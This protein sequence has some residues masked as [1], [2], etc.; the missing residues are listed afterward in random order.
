[1]RDFRLRCRCVTPRT[2]V[3]WLFPWSGSALPSW[4]PCP[5]LVRLHAAV[6]VCCRN[7][8][9]ASAHIHDQYLALRSVYLAVL[10][11]TVI[12]DQL[13]F[14]YF[15]F[16]SVLDSLY[17]PYS[18]RLYSVSFPQI[19]Y[20]IYKCRLYS[21]Q[22]RHLCTTV[23]SHTFAITRFLCCSVRLFAASR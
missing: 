9:A 6:A 3:P 18:S 7:V 20:A 22:S 19:L 8:T 5:G 16:L 4:S 2:S 13:I 10:I 1:M 23:L 15:L 17:T 11:S 21:V 14:Y 12:S